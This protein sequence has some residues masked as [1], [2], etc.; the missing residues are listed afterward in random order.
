MALLRCIRCPHTETRRPRHPRV[1]ELQSKQ[2]AKTEKD[3]VLWT[4]KYDPGWREQKWNLDIFGMWLGKMYINLSV[5]TQ[6]LKIY[7]KF[8]SRCSIAT[9]SR[10]RSLSQ[11]S[12][13][14]HAEGSTWGESRVQKAMPRG[15]CFFHIGAGNITVFKGCLGNQA[16]S[17]LCPLMTASTFRQKQL[18]FWG[19]WI[20]SEGK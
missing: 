20:P 10:K 16:H 8:T 2:G 19:L 12:A 18:F 7:W 6:R 4:D 14:C 13:A 9:L 1:A 11:E 17:Y 15:L 5:Q 3:Q